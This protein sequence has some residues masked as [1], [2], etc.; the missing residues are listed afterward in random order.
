MEPIDSEEAI[1]PDYVARRAG[2]SNR[3]VVPA[4]QA[5][6]RF[7]GSL[8][9]LQIRAQASKRSKTMKSFI[10]TSHHSFVRKQPIQ[11]S[12]VSSCWH[13]CWLWACRPWRRCLSGSPRQ[14]GRGRSPGRPCRVPLGPGLQAAQPKMR[15]MNVKIAAYLQRWVL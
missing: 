9:D 11:Q 12:A 3:V 4:R 15:N 10:H 6:N 2:T 8:K 1:P 13:L 5:E 7:L 14:R